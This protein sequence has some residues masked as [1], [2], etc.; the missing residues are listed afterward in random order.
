MTRWMVLAAAL[1]LGACDG[2]PTAPTAG[3]P[4]SAAGIPAPCSLVFETPDPAQI[5]EI[6]RPN[7]E[8]G[9]GRVIWYTFPA[10]AARPNA[11]MT[12]SMFVDFEPLVKHTCDYTGRLHFRARAAYYGRRLDIVPLG[13]GK[14]EY[15][16]P[17]RGSS[18]FSLFEKSFNVEVRVTDDDG[19]TKAV[20]HHFE[21]VKDW[22]P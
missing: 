11:L 1:V 4:E 7:T 6:N 5:T 12:W 21:L 13:H 14:F 8:K 2:S 18:S 17:H 16:L 19:L 22:T 3:A 20:Q 15:I 9:W 10:S